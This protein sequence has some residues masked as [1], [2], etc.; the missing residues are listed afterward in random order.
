MTRPNLFGA[1]IAGAIFDAMG[2]D[3]LPATLTR[4]TGGT[5]NPASLT[6]GPVVDETATDYAC[7]G[8]VESYTAREIDGTLVRDSDR[9]VIL[10]G[11]SLPDDIDP[12][13]GDR[14]NIEGETWKVVRVERD[15]AGAT[16]TC[17]A[18]Q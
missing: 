6:G 5:R 12:R 10:L 7:R 4:V 8:F 13:P 15:P 16:F 2:S 3:M 14:V 17:Q 9:K 11:G 1:N 18:R